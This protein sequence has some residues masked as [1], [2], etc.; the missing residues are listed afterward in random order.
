MTFSIVAVDPATGDCASA[1]TSCCVAAG[2]TVSHSRA[3]T[4]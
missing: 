3:G 4:A 2:G 1:V